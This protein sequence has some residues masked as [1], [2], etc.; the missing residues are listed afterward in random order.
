MTRDYRTLDAI[1][2]TACLVDLTLVGAALVFVKIPQENL[3]ILAG[4][5]SGVIGGALGA[6]VGARWG[7]KKPTSEAES[8]APVNSPAG[9][10][11]TSTVEPKG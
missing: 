4:L 3:P 10:T 2:V 6:Y 5:A 8:Q 9:A 1:V 11:L 7:N